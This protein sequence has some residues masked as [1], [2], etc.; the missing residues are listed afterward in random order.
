MLKIVAGIAI[1]IVFL[2]VIYY[3]YKKTKSGSCCGSK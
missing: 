3:Q 1:G 2:A